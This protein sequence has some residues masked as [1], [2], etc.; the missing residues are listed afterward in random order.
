[1]KFRPHIG[2]TTLIV[3]AILL[4]LPSLHW[5]CSLSGIDSPVGGELRRG[6]GNVVGF[7]EA[8]SGTQRDFGIGNDLD[9]E[10]GDD[11]SQDGDASAV[12]K[13]KDE[14]DTTGVGQTTDVVRDKNSRQSYGMGSKREST[15]E[16]DTAQKIVGNR[17]K[18]KIVAMLG[19]QGKKD[20]SEIVADA[21]KG[22]GDKRPPG[23]KLRADR[24]DKD[25]TMDVKAKEDS[26]S[27][28]RQKVNKKN[29]KKK[30]NK[31]KPKKKDKLGKENNIKTSGNN[32]GKK[33]DQKPE[34]DKRM[35]RVAVCIAGHTRTFRNKNVHGSILR[36]VVEASAANGTEGVD[37]FF[38]L[39]RE[40]IPRY[41]EH[42]R[43]DTM[44]SEEEEKSL[45]KAMEKFKPVS[46]TYFDNSAVP[47]DWENGTRCPKTNRK[48]LLKVYPYPLLRGTQ[49]YEKVKEYERKRGFKYSF[50]YK[51]RPDL[52]FGAPLPL[53]SKLPTNKIVFNMHDPGTT[54]RGYRWL[55]ESHPELRPFLR[56][57]GAD[58]MA[59][60]P[61]ALADIY[62]DA[63]KAALWCEQ[64]N[65]DTP[66]FANNPEFL[67]G[68]WLAIH[69]VEIG[70]KPVFW[71]IWRENVGPECFRMHKIRRK[72]VNGHAPEM[73][74]EN[75]VSY[76]KRCEEFG[77]YGIPLK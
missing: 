67:L 12:E 62:F 29:D 6:M 25:R 45:E 48:R 44:V 54:T 57:P 18:Q 31:K 63:H 60:I 36:Y 15:D 69:D 32:S 11:L 28:K 64:Y 58:H 56:D 66:P 59:F 37:V 51:L 76:T 33:K 65:R 50:I 55:R 13:G 8:T 39:G 4:F 71:M 26:K 20:L 40:D 9:D 21:S 68:Y 38:H 2:P 5:K 1:M 24:S 75:G 34:Q 10:D 73:T 61:R 30:N 43:N 42:R 53:P 22:V 72:R 16:S 14:G 74:D 27:D 41:D 7:Q 35:G 17:G 70:R 49:C 77:K 46:I 52:A 47:I 19:A 3:A 23:K